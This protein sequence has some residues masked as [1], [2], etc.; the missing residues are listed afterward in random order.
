M[1]CQV[2]S[3]LKTKKSS[4][5]ETEALRQKGTTPQEPVEVLIENDPVE[6]S[7]VTFLID[8]GVEQ[9]HPAADGGTEGTD[10][11]H[12]N[13]HTQRIRRMTQKLFVILY[14]TTRYRCYES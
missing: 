12:Q 4:E 1:T 2:R 3:I 13:D 7:D 8:I 14:P 10:E 6:G 11:L 9:N 5:V